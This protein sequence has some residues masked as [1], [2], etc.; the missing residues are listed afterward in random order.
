M[1]QPAQGPA[2]A[3]CSTPPAH[4]EDAGASAHPVHEK[5]RLSRPAP[6]A[7]P[8]IAG[9]ATILSFPHLGTRSRRPAP[10]LKSP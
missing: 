7:R 3:P 2:E 4:S 6:A 10:A 9:A 8:H 5:L 1:A